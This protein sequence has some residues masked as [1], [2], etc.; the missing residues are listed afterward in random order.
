M[1]SLSLAYFLE[2]ETHGKY[3]SLEIH[4]QKNSHLDCETAIFYIIK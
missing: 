4:G 3:D 2:F 1:K